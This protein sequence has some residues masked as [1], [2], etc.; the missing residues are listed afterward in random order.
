MIDVRNYV[1]DAERKSNYSDSNSAIEEYRVL[2]KRDIPFCYRFSLFNLLCN[3][4]G[5]NHK[6]SNNARDKKDSANS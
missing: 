5:A 2:H 3:C 1:E 4:F 6:C